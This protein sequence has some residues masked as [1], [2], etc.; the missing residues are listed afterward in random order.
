MSLNNF[1]KS[2]KSRKATF[3]ICR[4]HFVVGFQSH[5]EFYL[6]DQ[7]RYLQER[8]ETGSRVQKAHNHIPKYP[9]IRFIYHSIDKL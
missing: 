3:R 1:H 4:E 8:L 7:V 2:I 9:S 5:Y 6:F